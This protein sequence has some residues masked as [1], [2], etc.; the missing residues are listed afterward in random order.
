MLQKKD[1]TVL[2]IIRRENVQTWKSEG[3]VADGLL[4]TQTCLVSLQVMP[5]MT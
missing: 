2:A 1:G 4:T 3:R 5:W